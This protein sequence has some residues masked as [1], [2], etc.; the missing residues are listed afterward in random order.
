[1][2]TITYKQHKKMNRFGDRVIKQVDPEGCFTTYGIPEKYQ[3]K[4]GVVCWWSRGCGNCVTFDASKL[5]RIARKIAWKVHYYFN[6]MI[7]RY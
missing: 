2:S 6:R 7:G 5:T 4:P 3:D 1:M